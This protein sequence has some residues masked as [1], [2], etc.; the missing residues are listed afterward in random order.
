MDTPGD[1]VIVMSL[2]L[3]QSMR[4]EPPVWESPEDISN[5]RRG[6]LKRCFQEQTKLGWENMMK[7][8]ITKTWAQAARHDRKQQRTWSTK[9]V[10]AIWETFETLWH[11]R[12][13]AIY[14]ATLEER[15]RILR[16]ETSQEIQRLYQDKEEIPQRY[17]RKIFHLTLQT[18]MNQRL[19]Q[20]LAW[21]KT[22]EA[23]KVP[24]APNPGAITN[25]FQVVN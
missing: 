9:T 20:Q 25:Y 22:V 6:L 2:G 10:N 21:L 5:E 19:E 23:S 18:R 3:E 24:E 16:E 8:I 1:I 11:Q 4:D 12:N 15:N 14:G 17:R 13:E 7:G